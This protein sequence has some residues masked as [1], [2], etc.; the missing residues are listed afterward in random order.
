MSMKLRPTAVCRIRTSPA[1]GSPGSASSQRS[2]SGPPWAW[3]R[4][5]CDIGFALGPTLEWGIGDDEIGHRPSADQVSGD[6]ALEVRRRA[7]AV[8]DSI[9]I[10]DDD[11]PR[12][13]DAQ[14]VRLRA[15]QPAEPSL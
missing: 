12:R 1:P 3:M 6:D 7:V 4:M 10:D 15:Q 14:A 8:P 11:R 2:T 5:A 9:G 13:T